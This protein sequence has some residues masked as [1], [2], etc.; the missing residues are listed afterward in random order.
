MLQ[1]RKEEE[2]FAIFSAVQYFSF[3][4]PAVDLDIITTGC[5]ITYD[6][7]VFVSSLSWPWHNIYVVYHQLVRYTIE[8]VHR[9]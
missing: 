1:G 4:L 2:N 8:F 7:F 5:S 9:N 6:C 3:K